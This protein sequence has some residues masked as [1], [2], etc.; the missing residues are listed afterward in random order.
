LGSS[1]GHACTSRVKNIPNRGAWHNYTMPNLKPNP[2]SVEPDTRIVEPNFQS[3][4]PNH[5]WVCEWS[6]PNLASVKP[7]TIQ[8]AYCSW[9]FTKPWSRTP[10]VWSL[11]PELW[12]PTFTVWNPT[13]NVCVNGRSRTS[14][15]WSL[16]QLQK[17]YCSQWFTKPWSRTPHMWSLISKLWRPTFKVWNPTINGFV[18]GRSR[19]SQVWSLTQLHKV[20][21]SR[22]FTKPR[23]R[24]PQVWSR[25]CQEL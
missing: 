21:C 16:T 23:S 17:A 9:W 5:Y 1:I 7:D 15:V 25:T 11:T 13:I 20:Y 22:R 12:S 3:V 19:T 10:R 14:Q 18:N 6:E 8:K 24:T 2:A 4:E